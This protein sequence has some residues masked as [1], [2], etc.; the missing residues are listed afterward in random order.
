MT[1]VFDCAA[2]TKG[3][4]LNDNLLQGPDLTNTLV[5]VLIRFRM[6]PIAFMA[7]IESM[8]YQVRVPSN[9]RSYL[10]FLW[11]KEGN[12]LAEPC[13]YEMNVHIFG[14]VSSP[15]CSNFALRQAANDFESKYGAEAAYALR[16]NFYVDDLLKSVEEET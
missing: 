8:F 16:K 2:K 7:D 14:A 11:W 5:G 13:T 12:T 10:R 9:Q 1:V 3:L 4:S 6:H 15:S